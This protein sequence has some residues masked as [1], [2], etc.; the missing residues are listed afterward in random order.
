HAERSLVRGVVAHRLSSANLEVFSVHL[1]VYDNL[2]KP[3]KLLFQVVLLRNSMPDVGRNVI[4]LLAELTENLLYELAE[5]TL[6]LGTNNLVRAN[7]EPTVAVDESTIA[8]INLGGQNN[9]GSG[10]D[11]VGEP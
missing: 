11:C 6:A 9:V 2:R 7:V 8:P 4:L 1:S 10:L 3:G 5:P